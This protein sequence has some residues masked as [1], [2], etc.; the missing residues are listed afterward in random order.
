MKNKKL[1]MSIAFLGGLSLALPACNNA[2]YELVDDST[3]TVDVGPAPSFE[4]EYIVKSKDERITRAGGDEEFSFPTVVKLHYHNDDNGC[5][6]R[7]FYT[8]VK[9]IDG[10]ERKPIPETHTSTD[11]E[12]TL[13]LEHD[14][15]E[16]ANKPS[17]FFIIKVAGT[18]AG[19]S[20]DMEISYKEFPPDESG[21]TEV[22]MIPGEGS[23]VE[24]YKTKE[25]TMLPKISTAKFTD[26]KTIH[27]VCSSDEPP[28]EWKLYAFDKTYLMGTPDEQNANK[29]FRLFKSGTNVKQKEFDITFNYTAKINIQ[30]VIE[31]TYQS[32]PTKVQRVVVSYEN[33]YK[34]DRFK[35]YYSYN[36]ENTET[37]HNFDNLGMS[38]EGNLIT[39]KVWSPISSLVTINFY[40]TGLPA[41]MGGSDVPDSYK[42]NYLAGGVWQVSFPRN[43]EDVMGKF[44]TFSLTNSLG[45]VETID[46]YVK[47]VGVNGIRGYVYDKDT[48]NPEGWDDVPLVWDGKTGY[49]IS[50]PQDLSIYEVHIRDLTMDDSWKSSKTPETPRGTYKA[51]VESGTRLAGHSDVTTGFDHLTELGVKAVQLLPVFDQDNDE[52]DIKFNWGYNPLN[53]N[54]VEG[55]YSS[56]AYN[57]VTR[58][59]E[60]KELVQ[61]F[62]NNGNHTRVIMDVVYNH[63]SSA[64]ASS[65][66]K[67]MPKY[68]FRYTSDWFLYD[69][70]GCNNEVASDM[71]MMRKFIVDSLCWWATEYKIKGFRFDLMGLIDTW[72]MREAAVALYNIDKDIY[73]YGEGWTSGGYHGPA[74]VQRRAAQWSDQL[75]GEPFYVENYNSED[76]MH[77]GDWYDDTSWYVCTEGGADSARVYS[78]LYEWIEG[79][80]IG[81]VGGFNDEGRNAL[82]G[83]ND[84]G[85]NGCPYPRWGFISQGSGDVGSNGATV[86]NMMMGRRSIGTNPQQ[87]INYASCHDNYTLW[88]Q[89]SYCL[90]ENGYRVVQDQWG[91]NIPLE[92]YGVNAPDTETLV[93]A[94]IVTHAAVMMS[95]GVA[96][97]QGG[98]E[99]YRSKRYSE[100]ELAVEM[101]KGNVRP[102]PDYPH[103]SS[104]PNVVIATSD[105]RMYGTEGHKYVITHNS[106]KSSDNV[107]SFK[108]DRK[109]NCEGVDTSK[110]IQ[111]WVK[112]I[113]ERNNVPKKGY[114]E[115][116][117]PT[118]NIYGDE[119]YSGSTGF[120]LWNG[121]EAGTTGYS[122]FICT[123]TP[124]DVGVG[125]NEFF[126]INQILF[127][128]GS[129][130][131]SD[132]AIKMQ[133]Y[134]FICVHK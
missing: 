51:F 89:L 83:S 113:H 15:P 94:S 6:N 28:M 72:T 19:Q 30:Y 4:S 45:T 88:D 32:N 104:D 116:K 16:Y 3:P 12:L 26:F 25:E 44:Y 107:N 86:A 77:P 90:N 119:V 132:K 126:S 8:W 73:I 76:P 56:D 127:E 87:T 27:C 52:E 53:Y 10:V 63:V 36:K 134:T 21:V 71:P 111:T 85:Y 103:Y 24:M 122:F 98:E 68:Y 49:D 14:Y 117:D 82:K 106:Y 75:V 125:S 97:M 65:F 129:K 46:P 34:T 62:A 92:P 5:L 42:M 31:S 118:F 109:V 41:S 101:A 96:F 60:Y 1:L 67:C 79:G 81:K 110:Y 93:K 2:Q 11:M 37:L 66:T 70:S 55:G 38:I 128:V 33:L 22:W 108:W 23:N 13:D 57:P 35:Y 124:F 59:T 91:N 64:T 9:G 102:F 39:F 7:R 112:M 43:V 133:P 95:N 131:N 105:V 78:C 114:V 69:G 123:R 99:L 84:D 20:A 29:P 48:T 80:K 74:V 50:T 18:W 58:I 115:G 40:D 121:N 100:E 47:A 61:A 120:G 54:C 130:T 17:L